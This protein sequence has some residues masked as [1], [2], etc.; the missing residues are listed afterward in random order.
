[1]PFDSQ[2]L[3]EMYVEISAKT[4]LLEKQMNG[5][6]RKTE[7]DASSIA[8][9]FSMM[10]NYIGGAI[11]IRK[12]FEFFT[13]TKNLARD[14]EEIQSK[15][16]TVFE[17]IGKD[18]EKMSKEFAKNFGLAN[19]TAREL[20]STT[21][22][23]LTGFGFTDKQAMD[24]SLSVNELAQDLA[25]FQNYSGG[26]KGASDALTKA[27][28]GET[29]MAKGLG[30]VI[31]Q[32]S[33]EFK[34]RI[35]DKMREKN[36]TETQAKALV[37]LDEAYRQSR[38]GVGDYARTKDSLAN[39]ERRFN[40]QVKEFN[41]D[42]GVNSASI[43]KS[44]VG[45]VSD[46]AKNMG[47]S[48]GSISV[49]GAAMK[50]LA[51]PIIII[52]TL[53][54]QTA[55]LIGTL[56]ASMASLFT[57]GFSG[58]GNTLSLG[59]DMMLKDSKAM[60][61]AIWNMWSDTEKKISN[62]V[63][64]PD[65][66][67]GSG[68]SGDKNKEALDKIAQYY[69][70]VKF[71][72]KAYL[73]YRQGLIDDE[74]TA[75]KEAGA[76]KFMIA[77]L[78]YQRTKELAQ[79]FADWSKEHA[80]DWILGDVEAKGTDLSSIK[81]KAE[82]IGMVQIETNVETQQK[83]VDDTI[84]MWEDLQLRLSDTTQSAY[85]SMA[86]GF[87]EILNLMKIRTSQN[88]SE[89]EKIFANMANMFIGQVQ[90]MIAQWLAFTVLT[91]FLGFKLGGAGQAIAV[92]QGGSFLGRNGNKPMRMAGGGS[93]MVPNAGMSGDYYPLLLKGGEKA[94]ITPVHK[95]GQTE[96]AI[97]KL[98]NQMQ[99]LTYSLIQ[100]NLL[101]DLST[102]PIEGELT[103]DAIFISNKKATK[104]YNRMR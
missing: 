7:K 93:F 47:N 28:L 104:K 54:K 82:E 87:F 37:I 99:I 75:L 15:F 26:A 90:R 88:A 92:A 79:E 24:L 22:D 9:K 102:I 81:K 49:F 45:Y 83:I 25:S 56:G 52:M 76:T 95:V 65:K 29:E 23:L 44:L 18:A 69:E 64:A 85:Y 63:I 103:N 70:T 10:F 57:S 53:V 74:I 19:T 86:D 48:E 66:N 2:K 97:S 67:G 21:G 51:T 58:A 17:G 38:K 36:L 94:D 20:L 6:R 14:A 40:E 5:L 34:Q 61:D 62:V 72:D 98:T 31:R 3:A 42:I 89:I 13:F 4:D 11:L 50:S 27:I 46:L 39:S 68:G 77:K 101:P 73:N 43:M 1:M 80:K 78:T 41:E 59:W 55:N 96:K 32:D 33:K 84:T 8:T 71:Q 35:V 30:I 16:N 91:R 12:A 100:G 60:N